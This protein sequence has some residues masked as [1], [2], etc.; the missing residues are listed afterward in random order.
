VIFS[1]W[2]AGVAS[3]SQAVVI[4]LEKARVRRESA[5]R[6]RRLSRATTIGDVID[7]LVRY[8]EELEGGARELD[9]RACAIAESIAQNR[10]LS[11]ELHTLI[12]ETRRRL[13][14][15]CLSGR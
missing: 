3:M 12:E 14:V 5:E 6:A 8:A 11:A 10:T 15:Y 9:E 13:A 7:D 2:D 4:L 1:R